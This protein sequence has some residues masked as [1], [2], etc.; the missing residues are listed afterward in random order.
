MCI[1][2]ML[3][4]LI[5]NT[6]AIYI[7]NDNVKIN[8]IEKI[9]NIK[10]QTFTIKCNFVINNETKYIKKLVN[11]LNHQIYT[12]YADLLSEFNQIFVSNCN[13]LIFQI[14][15]TALDAKRFVT[16]N[17]DFYV[18]L[19]QTFD[20]LA[21]DFLLII[22]TNYKQKLIK[23]VESVKLRKDKKL[24]IILLKEKNELINSLFYKTDKI[25]IPL[26]KSSIDEIIIFNREKLIVNFRNILNTFDDNKNH[27]NTSGSNWRLFENAKSIFYNF[28]RKAQK[29]ILD[30]YEND[31]KDDIS[32][33]IIKYQLKY[34]HILRDYFKILDWMFLPG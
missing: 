7:T 18:N 22:F 1:L 26:F 33:M 20:I 11:N 25:I 24:E 29:E 10:K 32:K 27:S 12:F 2:A 9:V 21:K 28:L 13:N 4:F 19:H 16:S 3:L 14:K 6:L 23:S 30:A 31:I 34:Y 17:F 5:Y 8:P 15:L